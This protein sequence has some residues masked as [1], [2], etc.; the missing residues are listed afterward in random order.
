MKLEVLLSCMN[1]SDF[2]IIEKSNLSTVTTLLV[3][4][5]SGDEEEILMQ[6]IH[7]MIRTS[8]KGLSISRNIAILNS[9]ADICLLADDDEYFVDGL[10]QKV[11]EA[12]VTCPEA[13]IIIFK[14]S[15]KIKKLGNEIRRLKK[16]DL[17]RVC[18][19]QISFRLES[20]KGKILFD[21]KLGAGSGNGTSEENKFLL[22]CYKAGLKIYYVPV[23]IA[24][25]RDGESTWFRGFDEEFFFNR[26]K[27]TRYIFGAPFALLYGAYYLVRKIPEYKKDI[28]LWCATKSFIKGFRVKDINQKYR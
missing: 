6:G 2:S 19:V 27:T 11:S 13:D 28:S 18:S 20:V 3:N 7:K 23:D 10:D 12:Y 17:L 4:Q 1:E 8:T 25:L 14:I 26:G 15:N 16:A 5:C 21:P 9:D 22:D 24:T